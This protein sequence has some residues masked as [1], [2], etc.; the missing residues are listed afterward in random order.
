M[1]GF[2]PACKVRVNAAGDWQLLPPAGQITQIGDAGATAWGLV[3]NDDLFV[4]GHCEVGGS[5]FVSGETWMSDDLGVKTAIS[6]YG[7]HDEIAFYAKMS[8]EITIA[9]GQGLAGVLSAANLCPVDSII[10]A[11]VGRVTQAPGGGATQLNVG[12]NG[13]NLDEFADV[14]AVALGTTFVSP[15]DGDGAN[16]GPVHNPAAVKL[17][18]TTDANVTGSDMKVRV[19]VFYIKLYPP[20]S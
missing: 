8:E 4:S 5:L 6:H 1:K 16:A 18:L 20:E 14:I 7:A 17:K 11:C 19:T 3:S 10:L 12:R 15:T 13:G 9:V 2:K